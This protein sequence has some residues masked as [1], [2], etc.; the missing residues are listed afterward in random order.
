MGVETIF[1][2]SDGAPT[3]GKIRNTDKIVSKTSEWKSAKRVKIHT[4]GLGEDCDKDFMKKL[5]AENGGQFIDKYSCLI[6]V[7]K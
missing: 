6:E 2:F 7:E 5:A 4:I 3:S 1:L